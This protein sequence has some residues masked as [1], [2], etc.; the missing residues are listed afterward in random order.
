[1]PRAQETRCSVCGVLSQAWQGPDG[2]FYCYSCF[3]KTFGYYPND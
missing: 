1:M 3:Y 2:R